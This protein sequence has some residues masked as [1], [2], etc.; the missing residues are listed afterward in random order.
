MI[1]NCNCVILFL[2]NLISFKPHIWSYIGDYPFRFFLI[3]HQSIV[4]SLPLITWHQLKTDICT[5]QFKQNFQSNFYS[6]GNF[7]FT[8]LSREA[9]NYIQLGGFIGIKFRANYV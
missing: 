8:L 1:E 4:D 7:K 5:P 6:K 2:R 3:T 9:Q